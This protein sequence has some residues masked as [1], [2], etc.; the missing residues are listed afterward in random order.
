MG[1]KKISK[2]VREQAAMICAVAASNRDGSYALDTSEICDQLGIDANLDL[3]AGCL[4]Y[5]AR[6]YVVT[7]I[8]P[9]GRFS[10][11]WR[12]AETDAEAE[13]LLRTG[14]TP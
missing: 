3:G 12:T 9:C 5:D 1:K 6:A 14:W 10:L 11:L 4:A 7:E 13:A 8:D 2:R